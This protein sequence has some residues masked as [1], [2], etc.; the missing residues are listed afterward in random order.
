[1]PDCYR[2][3]IQIVVSIG[4]AVAIAAAIWA[5]FS[6]AQAPTDATATLTSTGFF[7]PLGVTS[8]AKTGGTWKGRDRDHDTDGPPAYTYTLYHL[9]VDMPAIPGDPVF[10]VTNGTVWNISTGGWGDGNVA[11]IIQHTLA[12]GTDFLGIYGHIRPIGNLKVGDR[13]AGGVK[14]ATVG[15]YPEGG[16]HLH[17]GV[18]PAISFPLLITGK[19]GWGLATN[20]YWPDLNGMVD[21]VDWITTNTP[22]CGNA[23]SERFSPGGAIPNHPNGS[24]IKSGGSGIVYV[25][26]G[27]KKRP[28][29][30]AQLLYKLYGLGRGFDFRDVVTVSDAEFGKYI[31]GEIVNSPLS[32][33]PLPNGSAREPDGRLIR[34][35]GGNEIAIVSDGQRRP[36]STWVGFVSMGYLPCNVAAVDNYNDYPQG[37]TVEAT[38]TASLSEGELADL[39]PPNLSVTSHFDEQH[40]NSIPITIIGNASDASAGNH[41]ISQVLVNGNRASN[42]T[43]SGSGTANW[44]AAV[45]LTAGANS[46]VITAKDDS[47]LKNATTVTRTIFLDTQPPPAPSPTPTFRI[48]GRIT[49]INGGPKIGV[50]VDYGG[51]RYLADGN[52]QFLRPDSVFTD[53]HGFY[54]ISPAYGGFHY[55]VFPNQLSDLFFDPRRSSVDNL[56]SDQIF[57]FVAKDSPSP[58]PIIQ[59]EPNSDIAVALESVSQ[60]RDP[61]PKLTDFNLSSDTRTRTSIF[62]ANLDLPPGEFLSE[63]DLRVNAESAVDHTSYPAE[64]EFV[65]S[66]EDLTTFHH[67]VVKLPEDPGVIG[68]FLLRL[69]FL[70]SFSNTARITIFP[71]GLQ[72]ISFKEGDP[73]QPGDGVN[74]STSISKF[75]F[76]D[77]LALRGTRDG[78]TLTFYLPAGSSEL[79]S[80]SFNVISLKPGPCQASFGISGRSVT[81]YVSM[82]GVAG[83]YINMPQSDLEVMVNAANS[84]YPACGFSTQDLFIGGFYLNGSTQ[85]ITTVDAVSLGR[86][87]SLYSGT[88]VVSGPQYGTHPR[89]F[90]VLRR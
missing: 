72:F 24:L 27:G 47:P 63:G 26:Q 73:K 12:N 46:I 83:S 90:L 13:V 57:N 42:D 30:S 39:T 81:G 16:N 14:F 50:E 58:A 77:P 69:N 60:L 88:P 87:Q 80:M 70:G 8:W 66:L 6:F 55:N 29:S 52:V 85:P 49:D 43:A 53:N 37:A 48:S 17:L 21:P 18:H 1:M 4:V 75:T 25:L 10:A 71:I 79:K 64:V 11:V 68:D 41:G 36:F 15:P 78:F 76:S 33:S 84:I 51:Y 3:L 54:T 5:P 31:L 86:G 62:V 44:N 67:L 9:G 22:K 74:V 82:N 32:I 2:S 89:A 20:S 34:Q 7:Y 23:T 59:T 65:T 35:R 38:M 61:F 45:G 40:V 56:N 28:I 19:I